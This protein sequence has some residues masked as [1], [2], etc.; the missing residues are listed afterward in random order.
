MQ[1][2]NEKDFK[3]V[4]I[5]KQRDCIQ[6]SMVAESIRR[7]SL[8]S[9]ASSSSQTDDEITVDKPYLLS[10]P[11]YAT[12]SL[13]MMG[14]NDDISSHSLTEDDHSDTLLNRMEE[15]HISDDEEMNHKWPNSRISS[16]ITRGGEEEEEERSRDRHPLSPPDYD[17]I[18]PRRSSAP[19]FPF[20]HHHQNSIEGYDQRRS[21]YSE[22]TMNE[23]NRSRR[24][25]ETLPIYTCTVQKMGYAKAKIECDS[26]GI[27]AKRRPWRDVYMELQGTILKI[28]ENKRSSSSIGGYRYLP[29]MSPYYNQD[30]R[31]TFLVNLSLAN[32]KIDTATD[33]HKRPHVFRITTKN[34][35]QIL[36]HVQTNAAALLWIEKISAG[37]NISIDLEYQCMPNAS[38]ATFLFNNESSNM[39]YSQA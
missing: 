19:T 10:P 1:M 31:Y 39:N 9:N 22:G 2:T 30:I 4:G 20:H 14:N 33:Y 5:H 25:E 23:P 7:S 12:T 35:P 3:H 26:P 34:G 8:V 38:P 29:T 13:G 32:A 28:Y 15:L 21:S 36:F 16:I 27:K 17:T 18:M 6:L 11:L 37:I 24:R